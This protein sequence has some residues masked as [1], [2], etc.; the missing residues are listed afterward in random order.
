MALSVQLSLASTSA[1]SSIDSRKQAQALG[2]KIYTQGK[3]TSGKAS[4]GKSLAPSYLFACINCHGRDGEGKSEAGIRAPNI[5]LSRLNYHYKIHHK[6]EAGYSEQHLKSMVLNGEIKSMRQ[7]APNTSPSKLMPRYQLSPEEVSGL[8]AYLNV[9]GQTQVAGID[10][11]KL[12]LGVILPEELNQQQATKALLS[13]YFDEINHSGGRYQRQ[14]QFDFIP[15][16]A[17]DTQLDVQQVI[18][19]YFILLNINPDGHGLALPELAPTL[20]LSLFADKN[21]GIQSQTPS[22]RARSYALYQKNYSQN[23]SHISTQQLSH[24]AAQQGYVFHHPEQLCQGGFEAYIH[25]ENNKP[26][27]SKAALLLNSDN[28]YQFKRPLLTQIKQAQ[29]SLC[30]P[31]LFIV[32]SRHQADEVKLALQI[33]PASVF[34]LM[35]PNMQMVDLV[36]QQ[37]YLHLAKHSKAGLPMQHLNLQM[38]LAALAQVLDKLITDG[39]RKL[40]VTLVERQLQQFYHFETHFGPPL[41]FVANRKVGANGVMLVAVGGAESTMEEGYVWLEFEGE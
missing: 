6:S 3:T 8:Y 19:R 23:Y 11:T 38:H 15:R 2:Q 31:A 10:D 9:L 29:A 24:F 32:N 37:K 33:Y 27:A 7:V 36:G 17:F 16:S 39:G 1:H 41:S 34:A 14:I 25:G 35:P 4:L 30:T 40:D 28:S 12:R 21:S 22:T 5:Q 20:V 26:T 18:S 13:A